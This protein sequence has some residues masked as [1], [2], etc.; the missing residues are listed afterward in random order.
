MNRLWWALG[1]VLLILASLVCLLPG[2]D[3]PG[4]VE[5]NDKLAHALG[6]AALAGYFTG[7]V[8]RSNWW[9]IL[10]WLLVFGISIE[11]AQHFMQVGREADPRDV[12]ANSGGDLLGLLLGF[13][14][15]SRWP[16]AMDWV[17]RRRVTS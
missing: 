3:I 15:L 17:F 8:A 9:K 2:R 1:I 14:G 16:K 7:L 5:M 13:L 12:L 10:L 4:G 6:H 11:I